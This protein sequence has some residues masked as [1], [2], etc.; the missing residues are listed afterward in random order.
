MVL[1][2]YQTDSLW[3]TQAMYPFFP[4]ILN[5]ALISISITSYLFYDLTDILRERPDKSMKGSIDPK[6]VPLCEI[7]NRHENYVTTSSCSGRVYLNIFT[8]CLITSNTQ[9]NLEG[10][11]TI[12]LT[13]NHWDQKR[14]GFMWVMTLPLTLHPLPWIFT[15]S[16]NIFLLQFSPMNSPPQQIQI[17]IFLHIMTQNLWMNFQSLLT[18]VYVLFPFDLIFFPPIP[19]S[20]SF[21]I[22]L[23]LS[24]S[25]SFSILSTLAFLYACT[26][27]TFI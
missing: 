3:A 7:I 23:Y 12:E 16:Y 9:V 15:P 2:T 5:W 19:L 11:C 24:L 25:L 17:L 26:C 6:I 13:T 27:F 20:P 8:F 4:H 14:D 18:G 21:S 1:N 22:S 10:M